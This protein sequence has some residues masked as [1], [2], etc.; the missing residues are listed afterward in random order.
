[1]LGGEDDRMGRCQDGK[2]SG[3]EHVRVGGWQ[4]EAKIGGWK[5]GMG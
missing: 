3:W 1:M 5:D 2:M 4:G